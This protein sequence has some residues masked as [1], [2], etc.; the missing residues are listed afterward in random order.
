MSFR[1]NS[2]IAKL[3]SPHPFETKEPY[4]SRRA[5]DDVTILSGQY[6]GEL[7]TFLAVAKA[8]SLTRAAE[9]IGSSHATVGREIRRLQDLLGSQLV[10]LSKHGTTL[11]K[12]GAELA[13]AL[14]TFDQQLFTLAN[15]LR[16]ESSEAEGLVTLTVTDGLGVVFV[17][18]ALRRFSAHHPRVQVHLKSPVNFKDFRENLTDIMIGFRPDPAQDVT[19]VPLGWLHFIPLASRS[20]VETYG[21]PTRQ[22]VKQHRFVD[23]VIYSA[24][25]GPWDSWH[26]LLAQGQ[27]AHHCDASI[28]YGMLVKAGLGIGLLGNYNLMEPMAVPLDLGVQISLR[29]YAMARTERLQSKPVRLLF[30]AV[31]NWFGQSNSWFRKEM[32]LKVEDDEFKEG[33]FSLF[34]L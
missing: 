2:R 5:L 13:N 3:P 25:G 10:I 29:L 24:K 15:T 20:Y 14:V 9:E 32:S 11:T 22:N 12:R 23:S 17:V 26:Q 33:Y 27:V 28:T 1:S 21:L 30:E 34:N 31:N 16:S 4:L 6:W 18:P 19:N 8:K 7:R